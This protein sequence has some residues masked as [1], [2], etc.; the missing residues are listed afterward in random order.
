MPGPKDYELEQHAED[1]RALGRVV[2]IVALQST[3]GEVP[4]A[5]LLGAGR[6]EALKEPG[7]L[8]VHVALAEVPGA[9]QAGVLLAVRQGTSA[10]RVLGTAVARATGLA[11]G[12]ATSEG[13]GDASLD[14]LVTVA[15]EGLGVARSDGGVQAVHSE[16]YDLVQVL[17]GRSA[18]PINYRAPGSE[19]LPIGVPRGAPGAPG[20]HSAQDTATGT[21]PDAE[22]VLAEDYDLPAA[23]L[24]PLGVQEPARRTESD[25]PFAY[26]DTRDDALTDAR[27]AALTRGIAPGESELA[28]L[29]RAH[30]NERDALR[31]ELD[32]LRSEGG[33]SGG[34][35]ATI[36]DLQERRIQKLLRELQGA[37]GEIEKLRANKDADPGLASFF[38]SVQGLDPNAPNAAA[39]RGMLDTV[40]RQ[41][42]DKNGPP[43]A[44]GAAES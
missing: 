28:E 15:L 17:R 29:A 31:S 12:V 8:S 7:V 43:G 10:P 1:A 33:L 27:A 38:K 37:E 18:A 21:A 30:F 26:I 36:T 14:D 23:V 41:N 9:E 24:F 20:A 11:A 39:K 42:Q 25:D 22:P 44:T 3:N 6:E 34:Q 16:L 2:E 32:G 35:N 19:P 40:F 5:G 4:G 13:H